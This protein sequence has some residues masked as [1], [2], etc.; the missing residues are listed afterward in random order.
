MDALGKQ[1]PPYSRF[2]LRQVN[3]ALRQP[4]PLS[5]EYVGPKVSWLP[6]QGGRFLNTRSARLTTQRQ[7]VQSEPLGD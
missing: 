4:L 6:E 3:E 2:L 5:H 1:S 7:V